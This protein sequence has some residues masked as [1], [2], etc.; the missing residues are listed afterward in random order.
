LI[1]E[2]TGRSLGDSSATWTQ[3]EEVSPK[4]KVWRVSPSMRRRPG[5]IW[6]MSQP[7]VLEVRPALLRGSMALKA[8]VFGKREERD[9][10]HC[11]VELS[12]VELGEGS[13]GSEVG[14]GMDNL[15]AWYGYGYGY[16]CD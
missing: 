8:V 9:E 4:E 6:S 14:G 1:S 15:R 5:V 2:A 3:S 11:Q 10:F 7:V 13:E 12:R 16:E